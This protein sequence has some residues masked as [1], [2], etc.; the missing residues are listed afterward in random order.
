MHYL[1]QLE[2]IQ[3]SLEP[4]QDGILRLAALATTTT[5]EADLRELNAGLVE[6]R[7]SDKELRERLFVIQVAKKYDWEAANKMARRKAGEFDDPELSKVLEEREK[8]EEKAKKE[9]ARLATSFKA[10]RR[11]FTYG[12]PAIFRGGYQGYGQGPMITAP[13]Q[14]QEFGMGRRGAG[15]SGG[16]N[17][18]YR[19]GRRP[20][21]EEEKC[22]KCHQT[23]HFWRDCPNQK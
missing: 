4:L 22:H 1:Q 2:T 20:P 7:K 17:S 13:Y 19:P 14:H 11:G 9:K 3:R 23:G 10:K 5:A 15:F 6:L 21:R 16:Q 18:G 8:I 12:T